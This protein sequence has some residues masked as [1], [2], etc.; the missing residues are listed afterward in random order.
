VAKAAARTLVSRKILKRFSE[1]YLH[2]SHIQL[3]RPVAGPC[4]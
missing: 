4:V 1:R 3:P 2:R